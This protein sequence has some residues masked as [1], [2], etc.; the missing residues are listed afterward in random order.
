[1]KL[2]I[3]RIVGEGKEP[4]ILITGNVFT[5]TFLGSL[6]LPPKFRIWLNVNFMLHVD[7][8]SEDLFTVISHRQSVGL[9]LERLLSYYKRTT[10]MS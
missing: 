1:M 9:K 2:A 7:S 3:H 8:M 6:I 5:A 10:Q 4:F